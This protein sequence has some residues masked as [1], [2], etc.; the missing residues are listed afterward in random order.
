MPRPSY[1]DDH[2]EA[3]GRYVMRP[4]FAPLTRAVKL[5]LLVNLGVYLATFLLSFASDAAYWSVVRLAGI[6]PALWRESAPLLPLWQLLSYGFLHSL[7]PWH[8]VLN[9]L[10]L[11]CFGVMLE[12][13]LGPRRL[14]I[15]YFASQVVGGLCFL[16]LALATHGSIPLIGASGACF[17]VMV[18]VATLWP[19][20]PTVLYFIPL[21]LRTLALIFVGV[22]VFLFLLSLKAGALD[23]V[24]HVTHLGG[25]IF[26]FV[27]ARTGLIRWDP[28]RSLAQQRA[29]R[30]VKSAADEEQRM[31]QLLEKIHREGMNAL[32]RSEREFLKR[33]SSRR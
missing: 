4:S 11:Y 31:D 30:A 7:D 15:T 9:M 19:S 10:T 21:T 24:S 26:G 5:L 1:E 23:G 6:D 13:E 25:A 22:E 18:A 12:Q 20:R 3:G 16:G 17:G 2:E 28:V 29:E 33:V 14:L 8:V 32:T 27:A